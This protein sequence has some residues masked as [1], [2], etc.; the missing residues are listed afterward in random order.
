MRFDF[1]AALVAMSGAA[2]AVHLH[3]SV[4][5]EKVPNMTA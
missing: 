1:F 2:S 5:T 3:E 4:M